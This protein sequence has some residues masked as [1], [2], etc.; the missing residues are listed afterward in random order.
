M[1][2]SMIF[3]LCF[4]ACSGAPVEQEVYVPPPDARPIASVPESSPVT[5]NPL[6]NNCG[7]GG[8]RNPVSDPPLDDD[9]GIGDEL[10]PM[11]QDIWNPKPGP[12][13]GK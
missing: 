11:P 13:P 4:A 3:L 2:S 8:S 10:P 7:G 1:K 12:A 5:C 9:K 6:L